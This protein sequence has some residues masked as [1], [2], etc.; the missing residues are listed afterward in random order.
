MI[1]RNPMDF[2][3]M[4][5]VVPGT[6]M[7]IYYIYIRRKLFH[8][9]GEPPWIGHFSSIYICSQNSL[10]LCA[11]PSLPRTV[12]PSRAD[13]PDL[14]LAAMLEPSHAYLY[15]TIL[16]YRVK[17]TTGAIRCLRLP[18]ICRIVAFERN[19]KNKPGLTIPDNV[20]FQDHVRLRGGDD[21]LLTNCSLKK[22]RSEIKDGLDL[23]GACGSIVMMKNTTS[24]RMT[25]TNSMH[26][27][28]FPNDHVI[29]VPSFAKKIFNWG[30]SEGK[31][32]IQIQRSNKTWQPASWSFQTLR[33]LLDTHEFT[34][35]ASNK[36]G[37]MVLLGI[38][39]N[40][41]LPN[42][43]NGVL[44]CVVES[45]KLSRNRRPVQL[46]HHFSLQV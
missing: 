38:F 25:N 30:C 31:R 42:D 13:S 11:L 33:M 36:A 26:F 2:N 32:C 45:W 43:P 15:H 24:N 4:R 1:H 34:Q 41:Q 7:Q 16:T 44:A 35:V 20:S 40:K 8:T 19:T 29:H 27:N 39:P 14:G 3:D 5:W 37:R 10:A 12:A 23:H 17:I 21:E 28:A 6:T 9:N 46:R 22:I 18:T